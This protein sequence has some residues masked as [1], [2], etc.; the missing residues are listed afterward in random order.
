MILVIQFPYNFLNFPYG[1]FWLPLFYIGKRQKDYRVGPLQF[2]V[3]LLLPDIQPLKNRSLSLISYT[4]KPLQHIH[5]QC[6]A[7]PPW[8]GNECHLVIAFPPFPDKPC[9]I[10]V[11]IIS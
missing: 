10:H 1:I 6:L 4:E 2:S 9:F 11:K 3:F 8:T 7:K 5:V